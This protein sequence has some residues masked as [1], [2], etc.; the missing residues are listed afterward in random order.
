MQ[1]LQFVTAI[2]PV[3]LAILVVVLVCGAYDYWVQSK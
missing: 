2:N 3:V 1:Y